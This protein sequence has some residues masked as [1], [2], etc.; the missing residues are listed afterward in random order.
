MTTTSSA[1]STP[2]SIASSSS[3]AAA[4][5]SVINVS[6]LVSQLVAAAQTPQAAVI[7]SQTQAV[8]TEISAIGTLKGALSSFQSSLTALDTPSAFAV[9]T[10]NSSDKTI[11]TA[12][13]DSSAI[14]GTYNVTVAHLAQ[15]Q[16]IVSKPFVGG[17]SAIVGTGSLSMTLGSTS[18][19][20]TIGATSN[21][22]AGIAAAINTA[23]GN[24]G[25]TAT[26]INGTDGGHLVLSS[27]LTGASNTIQ[28]SETDGGSA[29][30]ALTYSGVNTANYT[31]TATGT[32]QD[33]SF[34][35]AGIAYTSS[36]NTV[37]NALSGVTLNL[38][39]TTGT[40]AGATLTVASDTTT[41]SS[42]ISNFVSAYNAMQSSLASLGSYDASTGTAGP[43]LGDPLLQGAQSQIRQAL[44]AV[45]N[46]GSAAYNTLTS[47]GI[48]TKSDGTLSLDTGTLATALATNPGAVTQLF[49]GANGIAATLNTQLTKELAAGGTVDSR[50]Q[51]LIK[52]ENSLTQ[53]SDDLNTRMAALS[54]SLTQQFSSLNTLLSSLQTTSAYLSQAF[55]SLPSVQSKSNG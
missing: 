25:I 15:A 11:F 43:L 50:S 51:T 30:S 4:G 8:T 35:I 48:T 41:I 34:S 17:S 9:Q 53:Q 1:T 14:P 23:S 13:A 7:S 52:Q 3:A 20:V 6:S 31:Q 33:A 46:T 27:S 37:S 44:N 29:L 19:N 10:A 21:T 22:L 16:Q 39:G 5:G 2:V 54:A 26:I 47:V 28:V 24:P 42:N 38:T 45:V 36:S 12:S 18:F 32:P 49:S 55:A 40:T